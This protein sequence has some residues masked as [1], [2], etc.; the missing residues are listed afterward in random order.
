MDG[1]AR[2]GNL[3]LSRRK[4]ILVCVQVVTLQGKL[5]VMPA[6]T[7]SLARQ[8]GI[9]DLGRHVVGVLLHRASGKGP[10]KAMAGA[11]Y[12]A[13]QAGI[14]ARVIDTNTLRG[15]EAPIM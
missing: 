9:I 15:A 14:M 13:L 12:A 10:G 8:P 2:A 4:L 11:G 7:V 3:D 1:Y 5:A 6:V